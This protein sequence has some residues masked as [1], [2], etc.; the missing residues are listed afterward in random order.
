MKKWNLYLD[1]SDASTVELT[2]C[3]EKEWEKLIEAISK[4]QPVIRVG[5]ALAVVS[6]H[7]VRVRR[8]ETE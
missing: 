8:K 2:G 4:K 1:L 6:S 7:I 3:D 5:S